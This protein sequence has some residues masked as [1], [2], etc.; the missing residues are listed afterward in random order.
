MF[1]DADMSVQL[2]Y[3]VNYAFVSYYCIPMTYMHG[4]LKVYPGLQ[5]LQRTQAHGNCTHMHA[6]S[7]K[8]VIR[9][10]T[11]SLSTLANYTPSHKRTIA[12][13]TITSTFSINQSNNHS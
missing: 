9:A 8:Q 10:V 6:T 4:Y 2:P 11:L 12:I 7:S 3:P 1:K 5:G 13:T